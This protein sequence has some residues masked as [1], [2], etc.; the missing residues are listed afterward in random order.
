MTNGQGGESVEEQLVRVAGAVA[1]KV[2]ELVA[3]PEGRVHAETAIASI[4]A[5]GGALVLRAT[6]GDQLAS[7]EPG[8]AV[9]VDEVNITGQELLG[10]LMSAATQ[11]GVEWDVSGEPPPDDNQ[12]HGAIVDLV[13]MVEPD[14][15]R[16]L[17]REG[18]APEDRPM[19]C[20]LAALDLVQRTAA[21]L[22]PS[23]ATRVV[24]DAL[25]AGSKTVPRPLEH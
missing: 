2:V 7:L 5:T 18:V 1:T 15:V 20:L 22:D 17:E 14:V 3:D 10:S 23:I 6:L 4:A 16:V 21:V 25:V 12:P 24:T 11:V 9:L 8:S 19:C 13:H